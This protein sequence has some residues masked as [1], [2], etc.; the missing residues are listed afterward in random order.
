[1]ILLV[2]FFEFIYYLIFFQDHISYIAGKDRER[3]CQLQLVIKT[4]QSIIIS[5]EFEME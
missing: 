1:M 4:K 2:F 3:P 5:F